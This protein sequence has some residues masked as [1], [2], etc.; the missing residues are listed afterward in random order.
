MNINTA[1]TE[2]EMIDNFFKIL[3]AKDFLN[4]DYFTYFLK[5]FLNDDS[6]F[7]EDLFETKIEEIYEFISNNDATCI[8]PNNCYELDEETIENIITQNRMWYEWYPDFSE[9]ILTH[10]EW[11]L[12]KMD[13]DMDI[14]DE[15]I[16]KVKKWIY[17]YLNNFY[18]QEFY[19]ENIQISVEEV[20]EKIIEI[21][22]HKKD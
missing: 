11:W 10:I 4:R 20:A 5:S 17:D 19:H 14:S 2:N 16:D 18:E 15:D 8:R 21:L 9:D 7:D 3:I 12:I 1:N 22:K 13:T 6:A